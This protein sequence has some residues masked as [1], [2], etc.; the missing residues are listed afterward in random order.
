MRIE[1]EFWHL[2]FGMMVSWSKFDLT[3][4]ACRE[5]VIAVPAVMEANGIA[6][7]RMACALCRKCDGCSLN[8]LG[9]HNYLKLPFLDDTRGR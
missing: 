5:C 7:A 2:V 8:S 4:L 6:G 3:G 9:Q 1:S